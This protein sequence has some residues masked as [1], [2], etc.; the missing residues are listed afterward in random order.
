MTPLGAPQRAVLVHGGLD[1]P[2]TH[3]RLASLRAAARATLD[4]T[5]HVAA[6]VAGLSRLEADPQFNAGLG[7]SLDEHGD[8]SADA[9][10]VDGRRSRSAAVAALRNAL[11]ASKVAAALLA[12]DLGPVLLVGEGAERFALRAGFPPSDVVTPERRRHLRSVVGGSATGIGSDTVGSIAVRNDSIAAGGS[13]GGITGK[14]VGRV[15]DAA[16]NGA[17]MYADAEVGVLCCGSGEVAIDYNLASR[18]AFMCSDAPSVVSALTSILTLVR[19]RPNG[20]IGVML[21]QRRARRFLIAHNSRHL[22]ACVISTKG[23]VVLDPPAFEVAVA[24]C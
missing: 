1:H 13:S 11:H 4:A 19:E 15:G 5:D 2:A 14:R 23:E 22:Q 24:E 9:G 10:L 12:E 6:V 8:A 21:Y 18:V 17:G 3:G 20:E 7:M 16:I